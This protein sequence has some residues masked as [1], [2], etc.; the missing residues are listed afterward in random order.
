MLRI[1]RSLLVAALSLPAFPIAAAT[2]LALD[3]ALAKAERTSPQLAAQRAAAEAA[4]ALV[5]SAGQN[6]DPKLVFGVENVPVQGGD[7]WSLTADSMTMRR[8]G[9]MQDFVRGE[10]RELR[11]ARAAA[12]ARREETMISMQ[13]ADLRREVATAWFERYYAERARQLAIELARETKAQAATAAAAVAAGRSGSPEAVA[14]RAMQLAIEDRILEID[15]QARRAEAQL[16]RWIEADALRPP[17]NPPDVFTLPHARDGAGDLASHPHV[18]IYEPMR[19]AAEADAALAR[20]AT[21]PDWNVELSYGQRGPAYDN[22][23]SLM[24]R[25]D[26]PL[27]SARRQDPVA[28]SRAKAVE[29]V[30]AQADEATR[31]H[32]A[33]IRA[34]V[35]DWEIGKERV[36]RYRAGIVPLAEERVRLAT[37]AYQGARADLASVFEA[38]RNVFEQKVAALNAEFEVARAWAQLAFLVPERSAR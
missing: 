24:V 29:Q 8:V 27:F 14:A 11:E 38:R 17:A 28:V 5:G 25:V 22:M 6:P 16:S 18:A 3:E 34:A 35:G 37:A 19:E 26:L 1:A 23:V 31:R 33:E 13:L 15:R 2:P 32:L 4:A 30:R 7:R 21:K 9:V 36:E 12:D 20:A 10:K